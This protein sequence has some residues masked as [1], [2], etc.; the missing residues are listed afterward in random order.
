MVPAITREEVRRWVEMP[1]PEEIFWRPL[2]VTGRIV[3]VD[4]VV[5]GEKPATQI[6]KKDMTIDEYLDRIMD[7]DLFEASLHG[8]PSKTREGFG[9][10]ATWLNAAGWNSFAQ[11][12]IMPLPLRK[13]QAIAKYWYSKGMELFQEVLKRIRP[14]LVITHGKVSLEAVSGYLFP[15]S[16]LLC[17]TFSEQCRICD[18]GTMSSSL[19]NRVSLLVCEHLWKYKT[20]QHRF[21]SLRE[22]ISNH[23]K[24][25]SN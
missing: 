17:A 16:P 14:T 22:A 9:T 13:D 5:V 21:D 24:H 6:L 2:T 1:S 11:L 18:M 7:S 19:G 8:K 12:N 23:R 4:C 25:Q 20:M 10:L 3:D 15:T